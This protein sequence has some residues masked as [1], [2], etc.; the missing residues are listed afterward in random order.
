MD[1]IAEEELY[2]EHAH[3]SEPR[4]QAHRKIDVLN[5][6][7]VSKVVEFIDTIYGN[8]AYNDYVKPSNTSA[9]E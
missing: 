3:M 8:P 2:V 7:G 6:I 9:E 5:E 4:R 1:I